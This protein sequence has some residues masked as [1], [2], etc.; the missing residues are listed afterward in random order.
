MLENI[1]QD[2]QY[3]IL[4]SANNTLKGSINEI[5][6][7]I[8]AH[9][10][11]YIEPPLNE[12]DIHMLSLPDIAAMKLNAISTSGQRSKDFIDL[13]YLSELYTV[14]DLISFYKAKYRQGNEMVILK[15][16]VYFD[17]VDLADW[18]ILM[19][20]PELKWD[21]VKKHLTTIVR[22]YIRTQ[23]KGFE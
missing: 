21:D 16:L 12:M 17:D 13:Y 7:D 19:K 22:E 5:N 14:H 10:Y 8:I 6:V 11:P 9:R 3:E 4:F 23:G 15:S 2:F 18:P 20:D 1:Q